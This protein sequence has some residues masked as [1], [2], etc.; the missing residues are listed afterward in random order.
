MNFLAHAYLSFNHTE[1]LLGN[2]SSDFIKGK[3]KFEYSINIQK[4]ITLHRAIDTFTDNHPA[5]AA[6]K[7]YF[8]ESVGLYSGAFVDVV[9]DHFLAID[10]TSFS[11]ES[12]LQNFCS[13]TYQQLQSN[14]E[15]LPEKL[16]KMLPYMQ[17]QNWLYNYQFTWGIEKSF[18]GVTRRAKY[19][20]SSVNAFEAF[21]NNY[22]ALSKCYQS[23]FNDVKNFAF[24]Q[25]QLLQNT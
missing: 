24:Q 12:D 15:L 20:D 21:Q 22:Q 7:K 5:T 11:T 19:L 23:F 16:Q 17:S 18:E 9:Y 14:I 6:A 1:I 25:F 3:K 4:G 13:Q 8:K 2:M 10:A